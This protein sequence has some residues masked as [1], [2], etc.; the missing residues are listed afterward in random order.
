MT[1]TEFLLARIAED[2]AGELSGDCDCIIDLGD[3]P[4][5]I[6]DVHGWACPIRVLAECE[7]KRR[8]VSYHQ[9]SFNLA[10]EAWCDPCHTSRDWS[11]GKWCPTL[12]A[13]A[14]PYADHP[15]YLPEWTP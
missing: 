12:R 1:L 15:D 2:E 7:A 14:L 4:F 8:I 13:L 5:I 6:G 9:T 3:G 11:D 10:G